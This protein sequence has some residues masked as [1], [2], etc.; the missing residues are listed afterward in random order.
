MY[1]NEFIRSNNYIN[2]ENGYKPLKELVKL[3]G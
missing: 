1:V 3:F 2:K